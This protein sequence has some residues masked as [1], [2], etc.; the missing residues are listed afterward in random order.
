MQAAARRCGIHFPSRARRVAADDLDRFDR[1]LTMSS[2]NLAAIE[3]MQ[4]RNGGQA[5]VK[6]I[7]SYSSNAPLA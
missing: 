6:P 4:R 1:I 3:R 7:L 5:I 2:D